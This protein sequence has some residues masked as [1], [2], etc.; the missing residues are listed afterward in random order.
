MRRIGAE[1]GTL[2]GSVPPERSCMLPEISYDI[3]SVNRRR[4]A[5][6]RQ[7]AK[8]FSVQSV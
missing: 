1:I 6:W 7:F 5:F 2:A 4:G 3:S 8:V